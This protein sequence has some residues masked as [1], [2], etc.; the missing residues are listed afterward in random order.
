MS[1]L[2]YVLIA[3]LLRRRLALPEVRAYRIAALVIAAYFTFGVLLN[4]ASSSPWERY[5]MAPV[6]SILAVTTTI[7]ARAPRR[8]TAQR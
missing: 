1:I 3:W 6:A 7:I 2:V 5:L 4:L 8:S